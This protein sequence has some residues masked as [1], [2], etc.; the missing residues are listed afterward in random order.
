MPPAFPRQRAFAMV[1]GVENI[2]WVVGSFTL[3]LTA[4]LTASVRTS[5]NLKVL[6]FHE[7]VN[8]PAKQQGLVLGT[9]IDIASAD[10]GSLN[11]L[12]GCWHAFMPPTASYPGLLLG[13]G[14]EDYPES[15]YYFNAGLYRGP[16]SGLTVF[17][18]GNS[19]R[20]SLMSFYKL[21][22]RDPIAF[23]NGFRFTWRNGDV[24]DR[25]TGEKCIAIDGDLI[26]RPGVSN[27]STL[28]YVYTWPGW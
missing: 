23:D 10:G 14:A 11:S 4:R 25:A 20:P 5:T 17:A 18:P 6:D 22:H 21:H 12:E 13:T 7:L 28:V 24:T 26:G 2:N 3:P 19:T 27:V 16:T 15:A 8:I 1:R 9:M